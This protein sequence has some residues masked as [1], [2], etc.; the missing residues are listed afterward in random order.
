MKKI[1]SGLTILE[2][3]V[4]V[5]IAG[6]VLVG[7]LHLYSLGAI[8]SNLSRHKL[9]ALNIAQA[10]VE[11]LIN[12][13]YAS[14]NL[15]NYPKVQTVKIDTGKT[16]NAGDDINGAMT[17][18]ISPITEGYKVIVTVSWTDYYGAMNEVLESTI[19]S[20]L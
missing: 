9:M 13:S 12:T 16:G 4:S 19:T 7:M 5:L 10:E 1:S 6:F 18:N 11:S 15:S 20:Y 17:T 8:A 2:V 14:I 3:I